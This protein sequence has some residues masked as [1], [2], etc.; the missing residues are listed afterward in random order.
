MDWL[1]Y[2]ATLMLSCMSHALS[3]KGKPEHGQATVL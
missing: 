2:V 3:D 1:G